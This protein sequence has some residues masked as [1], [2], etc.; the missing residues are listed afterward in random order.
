METVRETR[1]KLQCP[2]VVAATT[3]GSVMV[4]KRGCLSSWHLE[5]RSGADLHVACLGRCGSGHGGEGPAGT[6]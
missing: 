4:G 6:P 5:R 1:P 3:D 2:G